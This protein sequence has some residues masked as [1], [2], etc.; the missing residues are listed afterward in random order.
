MEMI[1]CR[2]FE[3]IGNLFTVTENLVVDNSAEILNVK[4]IDCRSSCWT[5][6]TLAHDQVKIWSKAKVRVYSDS[7]LCL[8]RMS[9]SNTEANAKWSSQVNEFKMYCAV[10]EFLGIDGEAIM[11]IF[12]GFSTLQLL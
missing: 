1:K 7:V 9:S 5:R 11:N 6:S 3:Q 12:P 10:D 8:G 4:T 2:K